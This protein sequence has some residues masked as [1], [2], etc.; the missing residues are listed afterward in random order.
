MMREHWE[1]SRD[2]MYIW[3]GRGTSI[4]GN[5]I[6]GY[7]NLITL[8]P[9]PGK[10][11]QIATATFNGNRD[12]DI[13]YNRLLNGSDDAIEADYGAVNMRIHGNQTRNCNSAVS[14]A[15]CVRGPV[16]VTRNTFVF[17]TL[18]FKFGIGRSVSHGACY[19]D[20]NSGYGLTANSGMGIYFNRQLPTSNK[21]FRNNILV[22]PMEDAVLAMRPGNVLDGNC[23][24][25]PSAGVIFKFHWLA[26][27]KWYKGLSA[28]R[29]LSGM[30]NAGMVADP[31]LRA[32]PGVATYTVSDYNHS[33]A[34]D[35]G[36]VKSVSDADFG[37]RPTSPCIDRGIPI[38]GVNDDYAGSGPDIGA[39]EF[40]PD[41]PQK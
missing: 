26:D 16:Y 15:P 38:R 18:M 2:A 1:F 39:V 32:T 29:D 41:G 36:L 31:Q 10:D 40:R 27:D 37:L 7:H 28:F 34:T 33:C 17:R 21:Y 22:L 30:E 3:T 8:E 13:F 12:I 9:K 35:A 20:H 6:D 11:Q 4:V 14:V 5:R 19:C 25:N 24:W 23:Y